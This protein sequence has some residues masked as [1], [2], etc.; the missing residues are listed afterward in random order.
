MI[1]W[2]TA[3]AVWI[4]AGARVGRVLVRPATT[5]RLAIVVAVAAV[6]A[7]VTV[8]IPD[9][10]LTIDRLPERLHR[11]GHSP[12]DL[13]E[14]A[15]WVTFTTA[16]SVIAAAAWPI[17][18]RTSLRRTAIAFYLGGVVVIL[19]S[20]IASPL[21]GLGV[22]V[23]GT[24]F[25]IVT[26][27]RNVDWTPLGRGIAIFTAGATVIAVLATMR[28]VAEIRGEGSDQEFGP[29]GLVSVAAI[30]ISL[31]SVWILVEVW[32]RARVLLRRVRRLHAT[33]VKRFPEV[34]V[35]DQTHT[36][37]VL[38]A[39]D[40]VAH[41]MDAMYLQAGGGIENRA[42]SAAPADRGTRALTVATWV[43]QPMS[44]DMLDTDWI[45][46]PV[47]VSARRWVVDIARAFDAGPR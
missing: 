29:D 26:A 13:L 21:I 20:W 27:V 9:V 46:P 19:A 36:T 8:A 15:M 44:V 37:T 17:A 45:S 38:R 14:L 23:G 28:V 34:V 5:I 11:G 4:A 47:G 35:E 41:I 2:L 18:S 22:I 6:A 3:L 33:L 7:A 12:S 39:S 32:V 43:R 40:H 31:G 42:A 16:T 24:I 25:V 10:A 1:F 30:A